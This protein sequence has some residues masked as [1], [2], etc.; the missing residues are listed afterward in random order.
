MLA[1]IAPAGAKVSPFGL[2][3]FNSGMIATGNHNFEKFAALCNTLSG[4]P[5]RLRRNGSPSWRPLQRQCRIMNSYHST[6]YTPSGSPFGLPAPPEVEPRV[7]RTRKRREAKSLPYGWRCETIGTRPFIVPHS[8]SFAFALQHPFRGAEGASRRGV[9]HST[10]HS[11]KIPRFSLH[12][13]TGRVREVPYRYNLRSV[14]IRRHYRQYSRKPSKWKAL[15][16]LLRKK[17]Y[18][19]RKQKENEI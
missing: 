12:I 8:L 14:I 19:S 6:Q 10:G 13:V 17:R 1:C 15:H 18:N 3:A 5:R 4:E 16:C 11:L 9:C 7:L 2:P